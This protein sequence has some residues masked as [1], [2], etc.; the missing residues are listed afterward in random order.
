MSS[1][2]LVS[3]FMYIKLL[4]WCVLWS[5]MKDMLTVTSGFLV[6]TVNCTMRS[7]MWFQYWECRVSRDFW[8]HVPCVNSCSD[9]V[10]TDVIDCH[11][12]Q[13]IIRQ[14]VLKQQVEWSS[15]SRC[16]WPEQGKSKVRGGAPHLAILQQMTK[17][18]K[19]QPVCQAWSSAEGMAK[20][21]AQCN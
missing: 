10:I 14:E 18:D 3:V 4:G 2:L 16:L 13:F 11:S 8:W 9:T 17:L 21:G 7:T 15:S 5:F 20:C 1:V 6:P 12:V 19:L